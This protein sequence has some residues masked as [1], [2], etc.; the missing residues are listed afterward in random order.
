MDVGKEENVKKCINIGRLGL[1]IR[2]AQVY[3]FSRTFPWPLHLRETLKSQGSGYA[4]VGLMMHFAPKRRVL[5]CGGRGGMVD[6]YRMHVA[7]P[8]C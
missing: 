2:P 7:S 5:G 4:V 3:N 1:N 6:A 8:T